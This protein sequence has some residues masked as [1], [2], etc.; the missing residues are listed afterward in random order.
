MS[1]ITSSTTLAHLGG[2]A[3]G[4]LPVPNP[5]TVYSLAQDINEDPDKYIEAHRDGKNV[6]YLRLKPNDEIHHVKVLPKYRRQ[7]IATGMYNEAKRL[8]HNPRHTTSLTRKG[9]AWK[10]SLPQD[11]V[12]K[13]GVLSLAD[14]DSRLRSDIEDAKYQGFIQAHRQKKQQE[15][16][17]RRNK[18]YTRNELFEKLPYK[19]GQVRTAVIPQTKENP[20]VANYRPATHQERTIEENIRQRRGESHDPALAAEGRRRASEWN[21]ITSNNLQK[22]SVWDWNNAYP[23]GRD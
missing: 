5:K 10:E 1:S 17:Q 4:A 23:F 16:A 14:E 13:R 20:P 3:K 15:W 9:R 11:D 6:G 19:R 8:G 21:R 2:I 7:G 12:G 22:N 18:Q